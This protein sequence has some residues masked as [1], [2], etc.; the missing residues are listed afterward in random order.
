MKNDRNTHWKPVD[1][2]NCTP[3]CISELLFEPTAWTV[4]WIKAKGC[5][6]INGLLVLLAAPEEIG[7]TFNVLLEWNVVFNEADVLAVTDVVTGMLE[8]D[9]PD[10][11]SISGNILELDELFAADRGSEFELKTPLLLFKLGWSSRC[12]RIFSYEQNSPE[13]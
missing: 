13:K 4:S 6:G 8:F 7:G 11:A 2:E 5:L 9:A 10:R 1:N 3:L 12:R